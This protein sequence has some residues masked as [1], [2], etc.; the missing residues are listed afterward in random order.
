MSF[1][2]RLHLKNAKNLYYFLTH[3]TKTLQRLL[4][5]QT[6]NYYAML[7]NS[8]KFF[9]SSSFSSNSFKAPSYKSL[10]KLKQN[11]G[12]AWA[13]HITRAYLE[14]VDCYHERTTKT[15][16]SCFWQCEAAFKKPDD[17]PGHLKNYHITGWTSVQVMFHINYNNIL[18]L[19]YIA[20][21]KILFNI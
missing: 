13:Q 9:H 17:T 12:S 16:A 10:H 6:A 20:A 3:W 21:Y 4:L 19:L 2:I 5:L 8:N 7:K 11:T 1:T 18:V 14:T 15:N